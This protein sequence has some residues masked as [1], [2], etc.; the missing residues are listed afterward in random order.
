MNN[1]SDRPCPEQ[2]DLDRRQFIAAIGGAAVAGSLSL[3]TTNSAVAA[4]S[5]TSGTETA[6]AELYET[7]S[8][9]QRGVICMP[10]NHKLRQKISANWHI[11]EPE[12]GSD[13]YS[14]AQRDLIR[15][16]VKS[17]S[18][19]DGHERLMK[20]MEDDSGG[21]EQYSCAIFGKPGSNE[22]EFELT[23]RHLTLRADGNTVKGAAF[24]GPIVYGHSEEDDPEQNVF[25]Y[26][27]KQVNKVFAALDP[28]QAKHALIDRA[29]KEN[30]IKV[31]DFDGQFPG[32]S[33][34][35]MSADQKQ[36]VSESL[37]VLLAPF[38][39]ED[40]EEVMAMVKANGGIDNLNMAFYQ[41]GDLKKDKVWDIWRVEGPGFVWHFRGAPHVHAYINI[42]TPKTS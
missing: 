23:G 11:T 16:A 33:I 36:L 30:A 42:A 39:A 5:A 1:P 18:S 22:C 7:L 35:E 19:D 12:I 29:P 25:H 20:Q 40:A 13:F 14:A 32:L 2:C 41:Q 9:Q 8:S 3:G 34:G 38:R 37:R 26:Q 17:L 28:H 21:I 6:V 24:G 15:R 31:Q 27:A 4:P 10:F